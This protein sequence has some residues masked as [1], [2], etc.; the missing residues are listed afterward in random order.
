MAAVAPARDAAW[1]CGAGSGQASLPLADRFARIH[2]TDASAT[3]LAA[4]PV[5]E[6]ITWSVVPAESSGLEAHSVDAITV[7]Q[8]LHWFDLDRFWVEVRRVARPQAVFVA[9]SYGLLKFDDAHLDRLL[10]E[11]HDDGIGSYWPIERGKVDARYQGIDLPFA[12]IEPPP[13]RMDASWTLDQLAGYLRT[14]SAT[15]RYIVDRGTDPVTAFIEALRPRWGNA[16][17]LVRWR[18]TILA[19]RID[20]R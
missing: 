3:Q 18:L 19:G 20:A 6:R 17:R 16:P 1:D 8:A 10:L 5:H 9:W 15:R 12:R 7:A 14:W 2:A 11:F 4:A 13:I